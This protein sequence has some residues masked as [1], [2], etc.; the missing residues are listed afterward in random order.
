MTQRT[1]SVVIFSSLNPTDVYLIQSVLKEAEI[2]SQIK[3]ALRSALA[4]EVPMDDAR[5]ELL[6]EA[7]LSKIATDLIQDQLQT[8]RPDWKCAQCSEVNPGNFQHCWQCGMNRIHPRTPE[9]SS[10]N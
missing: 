4:G 2:P 3:G 6:V 8:N 1:Q 9:S 7:S 10:G 5:V